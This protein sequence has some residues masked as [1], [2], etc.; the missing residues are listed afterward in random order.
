MEFENLKCSTDF[1]FTGGVRISE[2][3]DTTADVES[4]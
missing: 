2:D 4:H 1:G 3:A